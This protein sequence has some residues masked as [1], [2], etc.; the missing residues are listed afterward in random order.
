MIEIP[1]DYKDNN[2]PIYHNETIVIDDIGDQYLFNILALSLITIGIISVLCKGCPTIISRINNTRE[3]SNVSD[4]I[5]HR[6]I[7]EDINIS[8]ELCS[9]C[10]ESYMPREKTIIL[11]CNHKF[12]S[13]CIKDW[14]ETELTCPMCRKSIEI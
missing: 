7:E 4:Y 2:Y 10:I 13:N 14:L 6:E 8:V 11:P 1:D 12:H 3:I 5:S 9:I